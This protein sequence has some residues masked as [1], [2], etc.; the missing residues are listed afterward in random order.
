[1]LSINDCIRYSVQIANTISKKSKQTNQQKQIETLEALLHKA[2][3]TRFGKHYSFTKLLRTDDVANA[4]QQAV[5]YYDYDSMY[6]QWWQYTLEGFGNICWP[7][8]IKYF[9]LSSG[10]SG[11]A[12]KHIPVSKDM[13]RSIKK[14]GRKQVM[15]LYAFGLENSVYT[16][17]VLMVGGSTQ[18]HQHNDYCEG[19]MSG[20]SAANMPKWMS[21]LHYKPGKAISKNQDWQQRIDMIVQQAPHWDVATICGIP[22][23]VKLIIEKIICTYGLQTIHDIWPNFKLYIHGGVSA[24][25]YYASMQALYG[26]PVQ[27]IET[28]M[29]SEGSFG[30][31]AK[32]DSIGI[33]L[34]LC[35]GIF[36][37]FVPFTKENFTEDGQINQHAKAYQI[38]EVQEKIQYAIVI[39]TCAGAWRYLIGDVVEFVDAAN[40]EIIIIGRTKQFL[41]LCGEHISTDNMNKAIE[42]LQAKHQININE[43][44]VIGKML[45]DG[46]VHEWYIGTDDAHISQSQLASDLDHILQ[47]LNDDYNVERTSVMHCLQLHKIPN[48]LFCDFLKQEG[49]FGAMIKF[50]RVL[51]GEIV[52][53]WEEFVLKCEV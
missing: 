35:A 41:N 43:Y 20:I 10:T 27:W 23:W 11:G 51:K 16:K 6:A 39:S 44:T 38:H 33:R 42:L 29:A 36:Y 14:V 3:K 45:P 50:P 30:F 21:Y 49:K 47:T 1:M 25:P 18:L 40:A 31:R 46:Y 53:K 9:A 28:Y 15:S 26:K 22:S 48:H 34:V 4:Y 17:G 7:S 52:G 37:E 2:K 12:S 5:P 8:R 32:P 24:E 13:L 19:D